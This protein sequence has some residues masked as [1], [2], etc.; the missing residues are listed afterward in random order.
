MSGIIGGAG[1]RSGVIGETEID[2]EEGTYTVGINGDSAVALSPASQSGKY[3][4]IGNMVYV[5]GFIS[6]DDLNNAVGSLYI[7]GLPFA[8]SSGTS[9]Q[10]GAV[11][12]ASGLAIT[13]GSTITCE[14]EQAAS[15]A[16]LQNWDVTTGTSYFQTSELSADG[17]ISFTMTYTMSN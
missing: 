4:K 10:G 1:S 15:H 13:A 11:I 12:D 8:A 7:T 3:T 9:Q 2:Y 17:S 14:I 16:Y 6:V 5:S